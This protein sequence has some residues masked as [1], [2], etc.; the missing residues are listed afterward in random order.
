VKLSFETELTYT[1][2]PDTDVEEFFGRVMQ[3]LINLGVDDPG[4]GVD[5]A[6]REVSVGLVAEGELPE[7]AVAAAM[8][9]IRTAIHAAGGATP[10]WPTFQFGRLRATPVADEG[11]P[12]GLID[13]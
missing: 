9:T 6:K 10:G 12:R 13:A 11:H 4:I 7:D 5:L 3:E 1:A 2:A 8:T